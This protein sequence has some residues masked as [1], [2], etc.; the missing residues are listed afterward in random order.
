LVR[1]GT[2]DAFSVGFMPIRDRRDE[3]GTV[4]RLEAA[5]REVSLVAMPAYEGAL[6]AGVRSTTRSLS[7]DIARRRL[8]LILETF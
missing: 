3:D 2:V 8:N 5:L 6:V 7:V 1:S 4:V